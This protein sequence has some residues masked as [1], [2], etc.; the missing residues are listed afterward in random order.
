MCD[1]ESNTDH[2]KTY[3]F[4]CPTMVQQKQKMLKKGGY[5]LKGES[6]F[7]ALAYAAT[8]TNTNTNTTTTTSCTTLL[9]PLLLVVLLTTTP[10]YR[11]TPILG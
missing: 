5:G 1:Y 2:M 3:F 7:I 11:A 9:A 6:I 8:T 10:L 4:A